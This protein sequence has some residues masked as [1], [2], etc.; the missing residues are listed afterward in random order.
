M[1]KYEKGEVYR[2][3][4]S[5]YIARRKEILVTFVATP[6]LETPKAVYLYGRGTTED[7]VSCMYC[8]RKLTHKIS[9]FLGI[10]PI[11]G[12]HMYDLELTEANLKELGARI[13]ATVIDGWFPKSQI[14][15]VL[16]STEDV[17]V[18]TDHPMLK[19][20][21]KKESKRAV[22]AG[23]T[24]KIFFPYD[25]KEIA[26]IKTLSGRDYEKL[27]KP[28]WTAPFGIETAQQLREWGFA[29]DNSLKAKLHEVTNVRTAEE[30]TAELEI[31]SLKGG[32][33]Y[34]F[35]KIGVGFIESRNGRVLIADHMGLGKTIQ[36]LGWLEMHPEKRPAVIIVP[37]TLKINWKRE[38]TKWMSNETVHIVNGRMNGDSPLPKA[39]IYIINYDIV[40]VERT[41]IKKGQEKAEVFFREDLAD[42]NPEVV[43][44]DECHYIK[45]RNA[46]R[47]KAVQRMKGIEHRIALSGTPA[48]SRPAE[49]FNALHFIAPE[50]FPSFWNYA[51]RYCGAFN[52]G[53]G[54]VTSGATN[55]E[56]L[57][58]ILTSSIMLRRTKDEVL[59]DLPDK[60]RSVIPLPLTN[61]K[62]Y[63]RAH[64]DFLGWL[65]ETSP[66]A[67]A[68]AEGAEALVRIEKLKQVSVKGKLDSAV[69]WIRDY[70]EDEDKLV[71]YTT[72]QAVI[73]SLENELGAEFNAVKLDGRTS[74][75]NKDDA[76]QTF[77]NDSSCRLFLGNI[78]A[79]GMGITLT[80]ASA[81]C[82]IE[83]GWT[84]GD[85]DQAEDRVHRIGQEA[86]SVNAYYL[87][88]AG[89]IEEEIAS[90]IDK[91]RKILDMV[92]DG[93][94][95]EDSS[96]LMDLLRRVT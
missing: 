34:P 37:A 21:P 58:H 86:D 81:T 8:N 80:A 11:C 91:K 48:T 6:L 13:H 51:K 70:L 39:S 24:I 45:N 10:G 46:K 36:T 35:Q 3:S 25:P 66:E 79:A 72:H 92:L 74:Q 85:H 29:L 40:A 90:L 94:D 96:L 52:N 84:P 49:F 68:K 53:F 33:L 87:V 19:G 78:K 26:R 73:D 95:V 31:P 20:K 69:Q 54:W 47:T 67:V 56:E 83:L 4:I 61:R 50:R 9:R 65:G 89:T 75:K 42:L 2:F 76:V 55:T 12:G 57:H 30:V 28:H 32:E 16:A 1:I 77:Q 18:P 23:G 5:R 43:I 63:N 15:N 41:V 44:I 14:K 27:P 88:A 7:H 17:Q 60:V 64:E 38:I 62:E 22:L 93:K 71:V 82:F 59:K